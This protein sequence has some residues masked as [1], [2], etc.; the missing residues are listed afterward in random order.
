[1][2]GVLPDYI[3]FDEFPHILMD[4][5]C[6]KELDSL[7]SGYG[8]ANH[9]LK[10]F[11]ARLFDLNDLDINCSLAYPKYFEKAHGCESIFV[12]TYR[13]K[14]KNIRILYTLSHGQVRILLCSF[15][16]KSK[17]DY[18]VAIRKAKGRITLIPSGGGCLHE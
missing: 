16:E 3:A 18:D 8:D 17:S 11:V 2:N 1:M 5:R 10:W 9:F 13:K 14:K 4:K 6:K 12:I 7:L 15:D